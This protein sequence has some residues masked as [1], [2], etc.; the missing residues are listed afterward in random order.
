VFRGSLQGSSSSVIECRSATARPAAIATDKI[1]PVKVHC[2]CAASLARRCR[3]SWNVPV[4]IINAVD[5]QRLAAQQIFRTGFELEAL[6]L[7][8]CTPFG[9]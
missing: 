3:H 4:S 6:I 5:A 2:G 7:K 8:T 9:D 1:D